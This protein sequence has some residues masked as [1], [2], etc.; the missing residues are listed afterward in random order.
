M[1]TL[2]R[3]S[4]DDDGVETGPDTFAIFQNARGAVRLAS[5]NRFSGYRSIEIRDVAG[6]RDFP[7]LQG[8]L[9]LRSHGMVALHFAVT[10]VNPEEE[11]N[12]ALAGPQGF[13]LGK[14]GIAFWLK[15][16]DGYLCHYS[17]SM[18]KRL[19]RPQPFAWYV[20][21]VLYDVS[22]G[23]YD[24]TVWE[25]GRQDPVVRLRGQP[26]AANQPQ[27]AINKFSFIGDT[28]TDDSNVDY[29]I[30]DISVSTDE[31]ITL[32]PFVAPGRRKL[33]VDYWH[34]QQRSQYGRARPLAAMS[35]SDFGMSA[36]DIQS[37]RQAGM[38][39]RVQL[40]LDGRHPSI[41]DGIADRDRLFLDAAALWSEAQAAFARGDIVLAFDRFETA[42]RLIPWAP[43]YQLDAVLC[44]AALE[45]WEEVDR[46]LATIL[47]AWRD[48]MRLP[49]A[50]AM[51][52][53]ARADLAQ[54]ER[55]L[56]LPA[57]QSADGSTSPPFISEQYFYVLLWQ[58]QTAAASMFAQRMADHE[59][60]RGAS[61]AMWI[62]RIGDAAFM[63]NDFATARARY[64]ESAGSDREPWPP[65][66]LQ[67]LSDVHLRLGDVANERLY[68]EKVYGRLDGY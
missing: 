37:L 8:Y 10:V 7:E 59:R 26:N 20:V 6:D 67:K 61:P 66:V 11:L 65:R 15:T 1:S 58:H 38:W 63:E 39:D 25:Q 56:T 23:R 3:Y 47:D 35:F 16:I 4:F 32:A 28:G 12:I 57:E 46:R 64:E 2:V 62:E 43:I 33:F 44:L 60:R 49:V 31:H 68:R 30:D 34:E 45:R 21:D 54:A 27:S 14:D 42:S 18:P 53:I 22:R 13:R 29:Y 50:V 55:W 40:L 24:L 19:L 52:G 9:P 36:R 5:S 51:I 48:D 17:D 41:P